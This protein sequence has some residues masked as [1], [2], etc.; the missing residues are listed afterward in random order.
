M[1]CNFKY[2]LIFFLAFGC[3]PNTEGALNVLDP[4][5][6]TMNQPLQTK[7]MNVKGLTLKEAVAK[8]GKPD[9]ATEFKLE[10]VNLNEFRIELRNFFDANQIASEIEIKEITWENKSDS[11]LTAWYKELD[12]EWVYIHSLEYHKNDEF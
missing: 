12:K 10:G 6:K 11:L 5:E 8:Y 1:K 4:A 7:K 3:K 2:V 9:Y